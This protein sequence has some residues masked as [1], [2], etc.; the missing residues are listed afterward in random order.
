MLVGHAPLPAQRHLAV[1]IVT[2]ASPCGVS[3]H[4][5]LFFCTVEEKVKA[6][7][8]FKATEEIIEEYQTINKIR[9]LFISSYIY[10][11]FNLQNSHPI[12]YKNASTNLCSAQ[13]Y[14]RYS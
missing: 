14:V 9:V 2:A 7:T 11:T 1:Q 8:R 6:A 10:F 3:R 12:S 13:K 4:F 5:N